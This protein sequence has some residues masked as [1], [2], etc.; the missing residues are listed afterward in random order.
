MN[1]FTPKAPYSFMMC[2]RI[3]RVPISTMGLGRVFDSSAMR[4]PLPPAK[5]THFTSAPPARTDTAQ[6]APRNTSSCFLPPHAPDT[7]PQSRPT[8]HPQSIED[9]N[10]RNLSASAEDKRQSARLLGVRARIAPPTGA[11][12]KTRTETFNDLSHRAKG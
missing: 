5:M 4:V 3:G 12:G 1:S 2:Q 10:P 8:I 9:A 7:S 11:A 6:S